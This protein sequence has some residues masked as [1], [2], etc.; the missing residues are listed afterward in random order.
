MSTIKEQLIKLGSANREL[1]SHIRT[2]LASLDGAGDVKSATPDTYVTPGA[3]LAEALRK[4]WRNVTFDPSTGDGEA[5]LGGFTVE[6]YESGN[7]PAVWISLQT[8]KVKAF[9]IPTLVKVLNRIRK[10]WDML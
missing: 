4:D 9:H 3:R 1:R 5:N 7:D 8:P 10:S 2:I 6:F